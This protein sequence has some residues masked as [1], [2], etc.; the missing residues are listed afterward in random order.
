MIAF[1]GIPL[2]MREEL[3]AGVEYIKTLA[4]RFHKLNPMIIEVFGEK[5]AEILCHKYIGHWYP[6][7]P[8]KGQAF[9]CIRV[10][11]N[12][13]DQSIIEACAQCGLKSTDLALPKVMTLWIDPYEVSCR[14]GE[15]NYP[16]T[17]ATFDSRAV[18]V[19]ADT[20][21][22]KGQ[23]NISTANKCSTPTPEDDSSIT[24]CSLPSSPSVAGEDSDSGID[25]N[26]EDTNTPPTSRSPTELNIWWSPP[27]E[28]AEKNI[29]CSPT[30]EPVTRVRNMIIDIA[31][32]I[33]V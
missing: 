15:E 13:S 29:W 14:L 1:A 20:N 17:V 21:I 27:V 32:Y 5:L 11:R 3:V 33:G 25:V 18:R 26:F 4:N 23:E 9:R 19:P 6:E 8:I 16:Y 22:M 10:N 30:V 31:H 28:P 7:K 24:S 12:D 2:E